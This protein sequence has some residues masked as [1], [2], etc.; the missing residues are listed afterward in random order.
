MKLVY[1]V[2]IVIL[3][4]NSVWS[5]N[6]T[7]YCVNDE[8]AKKKLEN[9]ISQNAQFGN[10]QYLVSSDEYVYL[11]KE[12]GKILA[13]GTFKSMLGLEVGRFVGENL[14]RYYAITSLETTRLVALVK[15]AFHK[16]DE[17][18]IV[19]LYADE[20]K[21]LAK[22]E[23]SLSKS[24]AVLA[25]TKYVDAASQF[26]KDFPRSDWKMMADG[27]VVLDK[28]LGAQNNASQSK[29]SPS[30]AFATVVQA[31]SKF[32][33]AIEK[34]IDPAALRTRIALALETR[35]Q[36]FDANVVNILQMF[37]LKETPELDI[38]IE[39]RGRLL[40]T[41]EIKRTKLFLE[42]SGA[43]LISAI[44]GHPIPV[45][46]VRYRRTCVMD[47]VTGKLSKEIIVFEK[48]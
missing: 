48:T 17:T 19:D 14:S 25:A 44:V 42:T 21:H 22:I 16:L 33:Q 43:M 31:L 18:H 7:I 47:L 10:G 20:T 36:T 12:C 24:K 8:G 41:V 2:A 30:Q 3:I 45:D 4:P 38:N 9:E 6:I 37:Y 40:N 1:L 28:R 32:P 15:A 13:K 46:L 26:K 39:A 34:Q 23:D 11:T 35:T 29:M 27:Q 5:Y